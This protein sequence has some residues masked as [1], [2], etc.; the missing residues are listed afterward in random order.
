MRLLDLRSHMHT[1]KCAHLISK[2][3]LI[4][5]SKREVKTTLP[6]LPFPIQTLNIPHPF[7]YAKKKSE[8]E[9]GG[10]CRVRVLS[11]RCTP[12]TLGSIPASRKSTSDHPRATFHPPAA[13]LQPCCCRMLLS[14]ATAGRGGKREMVET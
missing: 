13:T 4:A 8:R 12:L 11:W 9:K 7:L 1:V 6:F 3:Q 2:L 5:T 14:G 10:D